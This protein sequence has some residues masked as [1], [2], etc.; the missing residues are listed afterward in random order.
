VA[1]DAKTGK[2]LWKKKLGIEQR[3]SSP[4]FADGKLYVAVYI[5]A[6]KSQNAQAAEGTTVGDGE[7]FVIKPGDTDAEIVSRTV[8][9][10]EMLRI[11]GRIQRQALYP[12][13]EKTLLLR[14]ER[15]EQGTTAVA[16][17]EMA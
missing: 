2:V 8:P 16:C 1:V 12:D 17:G 5:A 6:G 7:L 13:G 11:S 9:D 15:C 4:F 3:Q 14:K 10:G